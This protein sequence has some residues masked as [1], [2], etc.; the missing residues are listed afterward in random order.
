MI[1]VMVNSSKVNVMITNYSDPMDV[2][3]ISLFSIFIINANSG[4]IG[5]E[6][7]GQVNPQEKN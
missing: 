3:G 2:H 1:L 7:R 4:R 6:A 5:E